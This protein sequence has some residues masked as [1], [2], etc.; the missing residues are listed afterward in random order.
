M[1]V[2]AEVPLR[3]LRLEGRL[4]GQHLVEDDAEGVEVA[5]SVNGLARGQR[6][7]LFGRAILELADE[8]PGPG[9]LMKRLG[10]HPF[11]DPEVDDLGEQPPV[12]RLAQHD[13]VA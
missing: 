7:G 4:S 5:S 6:P 8:H 9:H 2:F 3:R 11:R 1:E 12:L 13:V 10:G